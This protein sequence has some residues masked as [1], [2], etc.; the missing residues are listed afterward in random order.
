MSEPITMNI[1]SFSVPEPITM[2]ISIFRDIFTR[3]DTA[4]EILTDNGVQ[5][6]SFVMRS[7][8]DDCDIKHLCTLKPMA[9]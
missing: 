8:L 3:E 6:T 2:N 9:K 7:F 5:F 1:I 4:S